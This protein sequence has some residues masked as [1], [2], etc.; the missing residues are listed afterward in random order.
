M[1]FAAYVL[2]ITSVSIAWAQDNALV[3]EKQQVVR[4]TG[5]RFAYPIVQHWIDEFNKEYPDVQVVIESRGSSDPSQYDVLVEAFEHP[6]AIRK[7]REY[8]YIAR[9]A[10]LPVAN[11]S[12]E[13]S[14]IYSDKGLHRELIKQLFFHDIFSDKEKQENVKAP[15][16]IYTR[17]QAAGAPTV[18]SRHFGYEQKDIKGKAIA[19]ADEHLVKALLRDSTGVS[20]LPLPVIYDRETGAPVAGITVLPV[21]LNG[22]NRVSDDEKG[23]EE[24]A[25]VVARLEER[26]SGTMENVPVEY[27]HLSVDRK[28]ASPEAV[29]FLQWVINHGESDLHAFGYL[30][31]EA[32]K[33]EKEKFEQFASRKI[34]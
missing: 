19:G 26:A 32:K 11:A 14:R 3:E 31:P 33:L 24:L 15:Y 28:G 20:Y 17:L 5:V 22:N 8:V 10:V 34:R 9:Y 16:T 1:K 27:I 2:L 13:F 30:K 12:S 4:V 21:D 7:N 23:Y 18:F 29:L 25:R 6:D